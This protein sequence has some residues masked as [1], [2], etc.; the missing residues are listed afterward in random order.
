MVK[1][2]NTMVLGWEAAVRGM[3]N[4]T[5]SWAD[6]DT[7]WDA[8][9]KTGDMAGCLGEKDLAR[10]QDLVKQGSDQ[11]KFMRYLVVN[12]DI[13]A[14]YYWW[15]EF[16]TYK[17]GTVA[18][19]TTTTQRL[20]DEEFSTAQFATE[21]LSPESLAALETF[22]AHLETCRLRFKENGNKDDWWQITQMLPTGWLQKRTVALNYE[23]LRKM[24]FARRNHNLD[25]WHQFCDWACSL[26]YFKA[27]VCG[28]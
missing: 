20:R 22:L 21:H 17:V 2:E 5:Y 23:V 1:I 4:P 26:P 19:S 24:Y 25:E 11:S 14:P 3:H 6:C 12:C 8:Y 10:M 15:K 9:R 18:N 13:T 7:D 27:L 16:S 28:E